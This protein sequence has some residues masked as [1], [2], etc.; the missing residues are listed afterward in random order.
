M[1]KR[2]LRG[3]TLIELLIVVAIIAIL[4]LIAVPNFLE[5]QVRSKVARA[6]TDMR[7]ICVAMEAYFVDHNG[8]PR[9]SDDPVNR[10]WWAALTSPVAYM[11][12]VPEP[13]FGGKK[14][15]AGENPLWGP[16]YHYNP[17]RNT[18]TTGAGG[19]SPY[20]WMP[21]DW[22]PYNGFVRD[23]INKG[24]WYVMQ[25]FGPDGDEDLCNK[26]GLGVF[27]DPTNGTVSNGD[28]VRFGPGSSDYIAF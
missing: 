3:F 1:A 26:D 20:D 17:F 16:C 19:A 15:P 12:S 11:T 14:S 2:A 8:Y 27:Y 21:A 9:H 22:G 10:P 13:P 18:W 7:S 28:V 4:A 24:F 6:K 5:A 25:S 23:M